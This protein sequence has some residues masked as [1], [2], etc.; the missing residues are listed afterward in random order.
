MPG[1]RVNQRKWQPCLGCM[2]R[3]SQCAREDVTAAAASCKPAINVLQSRCQL[4]APAQP[5][6]AGPNRRCCSPLQ[7]G[8]DI[9]GDGV[10]GF[11]ARQQQ[12]AA[13]RVEMRARLEADLK[14][15][16]V[17]KQARRVRTADVTYC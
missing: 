6:V 12:M 4:D 5:P 14:Q 8:A 1:M 16:I 2:H 3:V 9:G 7:G 10:L 15:Q 11:G 17:E 13:A